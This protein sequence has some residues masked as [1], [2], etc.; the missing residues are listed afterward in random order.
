MATTKSLLIQFGDGAL[1]EVFSHNCSINTTREFTIE[2]STNDGT[3]P[4]CDNL[5]APSWVLRSIDTLSAGISGAGTM[6]PVS[7]GVLRTKMLAGLSFNM[8]VKLDLPLASGGGYFS[9]AFI[10]NSLGMAKEGK[11]YVTCTVSLQSDGEIVW[12]DA[13]A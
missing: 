1:P 5:D 6:D 10:V 12:T 9:G 4:D 8:R 11:G 13:A 2:A 3:Q 7:W